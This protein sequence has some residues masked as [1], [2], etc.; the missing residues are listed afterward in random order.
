MKR[1]DLKNQPRLIKII[2][3]RPS[4]ISAALFSVFEAILLLTIHLSSG[5]AESITSFLSVLFAAIFA[6]S[7]SFFTKNGYIT[8]AGLLFT[9]SADVFLVLAEP[10]QRLVAMCFFSCV[11]ICYFLRIINEHTSPRVKKIHISVRASLL[12]SA[13]IITVCVLGE[14]AD[15]LSIV[16]MIYFT[17]LLLNIVFSFFNLKKSPMLPIGLLLFAFCDIIVGFSLLDM[18]L[19]ISENSFIYKISHTEFN[20][21]WTFY[22][23]SQTLIA[24]SFM[25]LLTR[26]GE[27]DRING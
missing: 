12:A 21:I 23:P 2:K 19:P 15:A 17:N 5:K 22:V 7:V 4:V 24:L 14:S 27:N 3:E 26:S 6:L 1:S 20:L 18:Y 13:A 8:V 10:Q 11:Q 16:S 9:V 25:P